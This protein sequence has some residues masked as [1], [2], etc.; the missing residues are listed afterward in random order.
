MRWGMDTLLMGLS[1]AAQT[2]AQNNPHGLAN[3]TLMNNH[4]LYSVWLTVGTPP[5]LQECVVDMTMSDSYVI[6]SALPMCSDPTAKKSCDFVFD[7]GNSS[8]LNYYPPTF[9]SFDAS[10]TNFSGSFVSDDMQLGVSVSPDGLKWSNGITLRNSTFGL[11]QNGTGVP[12]CVVGLGLPNGESSVT[13]MENGQVS[14]VYDNLPISVKKQ[15]YSNR[16]SYSVYLNSWDSSEGFVLFG[17]IDNAKFKGNLSVVPLVDYAVDA[18]LGTKLVGNPTDFQV[19]LNGISVSHK[20]ATVPIASTN[21]A[22]SLSLGNAYTVLPTSIVKPI[23][24]VLGLYIDP[25][26]GA[27][28]M[29]CGRDATINFNLSGLEIAVPLS[30]YALEKNK[31]MV[32][33]EKACMMLLE[34]QDD[35]LWLL[36]DPFVRAAYVYVDMDLFHAAIAPVHYTTESDVEVIG[37]DGS[38]SRAERAP[39]FNL[40]KLSSNITTYPVNTTFFPTVATSAAAALSPPLLA[41][42]VGMLLIA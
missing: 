18:S 30:Q 13:T 19:M 26:S 31:T 37:P 4:G 8:T 15:G 16:A 10:A 2:A 1:I 25:E 6:S 24:S 39:L 11:A 27:Y 28:M 14:P 32:N 41:I 23:A 38:Y 40:N 7:A 21:I 36:G 5:Q 22:V 12:A 42:L 17:G 33:G 9:P 3:L 35:P 34:V 20:N 29:P